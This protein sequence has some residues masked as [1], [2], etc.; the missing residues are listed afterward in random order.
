MIEL[1]DT[2]KCE[3][4]GTVF[5][6]KYIDFENAKVVVYRTDDVLKNVKSVHKTSFQY[7]IQLQCPNPNCSRRHFVEIDR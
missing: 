5:E 7:I 4:C 2:H 6:W 3:F 1:F